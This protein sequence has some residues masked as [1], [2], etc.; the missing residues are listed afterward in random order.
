MAAYNQLALPSENNPVQYFSAPADNLFNNIM[1]KYMMP[2]PSASTATGTKNI[3]YKSDRSY[4]HHKDL[5]N[6]KTNTLIKG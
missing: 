6:P 1:M 4:E 3:N 2:M 5:I